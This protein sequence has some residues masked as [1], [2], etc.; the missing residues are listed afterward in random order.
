MV[1]WQQNADLEALFQFIDGYFN[2]VK[3]YFTKLMVPVSVTGSNFVICKNS[4]IVSL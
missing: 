4:I 2:L 1:R 3:V